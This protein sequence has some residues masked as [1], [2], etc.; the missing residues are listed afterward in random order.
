MNKEN[1]IAFLTSKAGTL[2]LHG[3]E[4]FNIS[5]EEFSGFKIS[6]SPEPCCSCGSHNPLR[7]AAPVVIRGKDYCVWCALEM[8]RQVCASVVSEA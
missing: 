2:R 3:E 8:A 4:P 6:D 1:R 5:A 7:P